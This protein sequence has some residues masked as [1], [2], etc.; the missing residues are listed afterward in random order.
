M[1]LLAHFIVVEA[2]LDLKQ[3]SKGDDEYF[4]NDIYSVPRSQGDMLAH[5]RLDHDAWQEALDGG[6]AQDKFAPSVRPFRFSDTP[7][8]SFPPPPSH[9]PSQSIGSPS[10][11][12]RVVCS[13][14]LLEFTKTRRK[15]PAIWKCEFTN[16]NQDFTTK[17]NQKHHINSHLGIKPHRCDRCGKGFGVGFGVGHAMKRHL[18]TCIKNAFKASG[19]EVQRRGV[20]EK[21][22]PMLQLSPLSTPHP[23]DSICFSV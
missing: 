23:L 12:G 1:A 10:D 17:A 5:G 16:C 20:K 14:A 13:P 9:S 3:P 4:Q 8:P 19:D 18:K 2:S 15:K 6:V 7:C 11:S 21:L 22:Y